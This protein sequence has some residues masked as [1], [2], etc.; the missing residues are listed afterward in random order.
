[1]Q[2]ASLQCSVICLLTAN[3]EELLKIPNSNHLKIW[4]R[5]M[6]RKIWIQWSMLYVL[7]FGCAHWNSNFEW[8]LESRRQVEGPTSRLWTQRIFRKLLHLQLSHINSMK[9]AGELLKTQVFASPSR[10]LRGHALIG[11]DRKN[12]K[13]QNSTNKQM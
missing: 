11:S 13:R 6:K 2:N 5:G 1:M 10:R 9:T 3:F 7:W 12:I 4:V 8:A